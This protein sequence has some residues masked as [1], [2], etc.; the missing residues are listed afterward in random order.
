MHGRSAIRALFLYFGFCLKCNVGESL[1]FIYIHILSLL[2]KNKFGTVL[3]NANIAYWI[4]KIIKAIISSQFWLE[5]SLQIKWKNKITTLLNEIPNKRM[6]N[7]MKNLVRLSIF[8]KKNKKKQ[9]NTFFRYNISL[10]F[11]P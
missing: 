3:A 1:L 11:R 7:N 5:T 8:K 9:A 10:E 4:R 6:K 2:I